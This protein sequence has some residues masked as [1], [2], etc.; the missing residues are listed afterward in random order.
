MK[1]LWSRPYLWTDCQVYGFILVCVFLLALVAC[2]D[3]DDKQQATK[4]RVPTM[5]SQ[6]DS[7]QKSAVDAQ[8][9][10]KEAQ[11]ALKRLQEQQ[12]QT[13]KDGP[14]AE[15]TTFGKITDVDVIW[16]AKDQTHWGDAYLAFTFV[17]EGGFTKRFYPVCTDQ[18][19]PT[20]KNVA[21]N[22][23]WQPDSNS[24]EHN[25]RGCYIIDGFTEK[26]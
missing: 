8:T 4:N 6:L 16:E 7:A 20:G 24:S 12:E 2:G 14:K 26:K 22:F 11:D 13:G 18:L 21:M 19:V 17:E 9:A 10:A 1:K 5:Q 3:D 23:H 25:H 15:H